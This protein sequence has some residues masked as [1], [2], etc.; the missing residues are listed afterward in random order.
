MTELRVGLVGA[1]MVSAH[2][3]AGWAAC[4]GARLVA[5]A[6][7]SPDAARARAAAAGVPTFPSLAEMLGGVA[8]D[9]V[10]LATPVATHAP[11]VLEATAAG[12]P[13]LCQKPL[14]ET[15]AAA[16][17][18]I[19]ALPPDARVMVHENWRWR[20]PYRSLAAALRRGTLWRPTHF[21]FDVASAGLLPD[22]TGALPALARQPFFTTMPRLVVLELLIHHLDTLEF[23]FGPLTIDAA[24]TARR[25]DRV[26]GED[27]AVISLSAGGLTGELVG[28]LCRPHAPPM[29]RDRLTLFGPTRATVDG[30]TFAIGPDRLFAV[31]PVVGYQASYTAALQHF[32]DCVAT[33]APFETPAEAGLQTL[34]HVERIYQLAA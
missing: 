15:A 10:D 30:W 13:V 22:A 19:D 20:G 21:H 33:G 32:A 12:L 9:A 11:L 8:V 23:L 27:L 31:D 14:A 29:P 2:H 24:R 26:A 28:D 1:G 25:C 17:A 3:V 18:L 5:I 16:A 4:R 34:R 7:P 6:D